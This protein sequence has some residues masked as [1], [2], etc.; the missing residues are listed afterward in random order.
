MEPWKCREQIRRRFGSAADL[1][2]L[3][4]EGERLVGVEAHQKAHPIDGDVPR[5]A[6]QRRAAGRRFQ[7]LQSACFLGLH[8]GDRGTS[9]AHSLGLQDAA[10]SN[11]GRIPQLGLWRRLVSFQF[12]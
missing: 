6:S 11:H 1:G 10:G 5:L 12:T 9:P 8:Q 3:L 7:R 2:V 4:R